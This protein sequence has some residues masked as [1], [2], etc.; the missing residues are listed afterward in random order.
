ML[1][2][3]P[4]LLAPWRTEITDS[5]VSNV[6]KDFLIC[7]F[8]NGDN[9]AC[10]TSIV[11]NSNSIPISP[12]VFPRVGSSLYYALALVPAKQRPALQL[13]L[14]WWH[15]TAQIPL[16]IAD[17][18]VAET[19]LRWW[20]QELLDAAQGQAHHPLIKAMRAQA[21]LPGGAP[22]PDWTCWQSQL[23]G[24]I[25]LIHQNRW[26]DEASRQRH[27][28]S[29]SSA[30]CE[31]AAHLLGARSAPTMQAARQLGLGLRQAHQLARLGQ[32]ARAGWVHVPIDVLQAH[33]VRAH[34]LS[35]PSPGQAPDGWPALLQHLH[36][37]AQSNIKTGLA[38]AQALPQNEA[39]ALRP[40]HER[41]VLTPLR[42]WWIC[43]R[44][45]W[46]LMR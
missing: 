35:K 8:S 33:E 24:L 7:Q 36:A 37:Q 43:Q 22:L 10:A 13:W 3:L 27:A 19:K 28:L 44:V 32:D 39:H 25:D 15:E 45:R 40:L 14:Q 26:M 18:G 4:R 38:A 23:Q 6:G 16:N 1:S 2:S 41:I 20:Q 9:A 17:P 29:T 34:Q 5:R 11:M 30:A 12:V 21:D 42:K 46:G 31:G